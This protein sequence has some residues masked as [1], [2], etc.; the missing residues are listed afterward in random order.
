MKMELHQF[1]HKLTQI[2]L[3]SSLKFAVICA[4]VLPLLP[5]RSFGPPNFEI[6]NPFKIWLLVV[7]ISGISFVG[8]ILV[9][10]VGPTRG[11]G[12]TGLLGGL[13]SSTALTLSFSNR[14]KEEP[15]LSSSL[16]TGIVVAWIVMYVRVLAIVWLISSELGRNLAVPMLVPVI[17]GFAW[18]LWL[19]RKQ[20]QHAQQSAPRFSN[21][22]ELVP[23]IKF[24]GIILLV[25]VISKAA[26]LQFGDSGLLAS[27]FVAGLADVDAI[28]V[29]VGQMMKMESMDFLRI[30]TISILLAGIANTI[31]KGT[32]AF[33]IGAPAM[34]RAIG[35]AVVLMVVAGGLSVLLVR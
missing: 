27:S 33:L 19:W 2:D 25:L 4:I 35:P 29:S 31:T 9:K 6:F 3:I 22:F 20:E 23:A 11:I 1:A 7:F 8:Y 24:V 28:A 16:A 15:E 21:P 34:R 17:P 14:S 10:L 5:D 26:R 18:C 12:I 32:I 13:A 30:G